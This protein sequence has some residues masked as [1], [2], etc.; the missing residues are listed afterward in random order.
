V[1]ASV[2]MPKA[3]MNKDDLFHA[4]E[5]K[6]GSTGKAADV[7]AVTV[8]KSR[9]QLADCSLWRRVTTANGGHD[10]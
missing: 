6:I 10:P 1:A 9:N 8:A 4:L 3:S 5:D 7:K 2:L